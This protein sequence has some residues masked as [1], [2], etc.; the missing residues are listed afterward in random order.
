MA[1]GNIDESHED[2]NKNKNSKGVG[3]KNKPMSWKMLKCCIELRGN[4]ESG[5]H[6]LGVHPYKQFFSHYM[7]SIVN[8]K[9]LIIVD[10][11]EP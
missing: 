7:L 4:A 9:T 8:M 6:L 11:V 2:K 5:D 1:E 10:Q 3:Q